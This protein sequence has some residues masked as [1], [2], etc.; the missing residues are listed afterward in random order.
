MQKAVG[1]GQISSRTE[2]ITQHSGLQ[3]LSNKE[4]AKNQRVINSV[5]LLK[6]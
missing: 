5:Q 2:L 6:D 3:A 1:R 4:L